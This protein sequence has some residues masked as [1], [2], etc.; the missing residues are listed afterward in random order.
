M[1]AK[2]YGIPAFRVDKESDI[3][4]ALQKA[5]AVKGPAVID[6][7]VEPMEVV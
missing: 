5:F 1:L 2:S 4:S 7:V 6:F 3:F